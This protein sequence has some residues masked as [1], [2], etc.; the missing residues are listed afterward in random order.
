M[1]YEDAQSGNKRRQTAPRVRPK[2]IIST[3]PPGPPRME[4]KD[5]KQPLQ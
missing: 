1:P 2:P 4:S 3:K 5:P